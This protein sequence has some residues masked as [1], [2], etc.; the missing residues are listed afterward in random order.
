MFIPEVEFVDYNKNFKYDTATGF[1]FNLKK[2]FM[3][4]CLWKKID[5]PIKRVKLPPLPIIDIMING[6]VDKKVKSAL[7]QLMWECL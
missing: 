2:W 4:Y 7:Y 6:D 5:V 1:F 3:G